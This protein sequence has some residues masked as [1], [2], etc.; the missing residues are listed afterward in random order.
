M[1]RG[2]SPSLP[3]RGTHLAS[4]PSPCEPVKLCYS[5]VTEG[6]ECFWGA[7]GGV[8]CRWMPWETVL[9]VSLEGGR[10]LKLLSGRIALSPQPWAPA[11]RAAAA[12]RGG[13][14]KRVAGELQGFVLQTRP[15]RNKERWGCTAISPLSS[16]SLVPPWVL[17][18]RWTPLGVCRP[19]A[20]T[21]AFI[22]PGLSAFER[23]LRIVLIVLGLCWASL[24]TWAFRHRGRI[25]LGK[26]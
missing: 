4:L 9:P 6:V 21:S 12:S 23:R 19:A 24:F 14:R 13:G 22:G 18:G 10:G 3:L 5:R 2:F 8:G 16:H 11:P 26:A 1:S 17:A 20:V 25:G 15:L 7:R